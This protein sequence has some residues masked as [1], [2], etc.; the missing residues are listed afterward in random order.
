[1]FAELPKLFGRAFAIGFLLPALLIELA[2]LG[3]WSAFMD[4]ST[5]VAALG[6]PNSLIGVTLAVLATWTGAIALMALNRPVIRTLEGYGR[7]NPFRLWEHFELDRFDSLKREVDDVRKQRKALKDDKKPKDPALEARFT[8]LR[9]VLAERFPIERAHVLPT[10]FGNVIRAF[11]T[12][13][14]A[15]YG[16]DAIPGWPRLLGVVPA[17]YRVLLDDAKAQVDFWVNLWLGALAVVATYFALALDCEKFPS[18]WIPVAACI[19]AVAFARSARISAG[20]WGAFVKSAFELY[21]IELL[22]KLGFEPPRNIEV[23]RELWTFVSQAAVYR[24]VGIAGKFTAYR[25]RTSS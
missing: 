19:A 24:S 22:K 3:V 21:R 15:L 5:L 6:A 23:E 10:K 11:E 7:W 1:M 2:L 25:S 4:T 12:Y 20:E 13:P 16:L 17:D 18:L 8:K 14:G 9:Y